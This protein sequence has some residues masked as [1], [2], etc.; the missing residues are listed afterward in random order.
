MKAENIALPI[1]FSDEHI[2]VVNKPAGLITHPGAGVHN[3][4]LCNA[5]LYHFPGMVVGNAERPGIVHRLDKDTSGVMVVA[6]TEE[7]HRHLSEQFK[8]RR[9]EKIY[10]ALC[11]GEFVETAFELKTGHARHQHN[12][13]RFSTKISLEKCHGSHV[14]IAHTSFFVEK[15]QFGLSMLTAILHTGRTHQI[16]AHLADIDHP[17]LGDEIYGGKRV[18]SGRVPEDLRAAIG[19][20]KGQALHAEVLRFFHPKYGEKL[21][22]TV[23]P[24]EPFLRVARMIP[25]RNFLT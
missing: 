4:T 6:K 13:L 18:I 16:R 17:L 5:L 7:A 21:S 14:R 24:P 20:L 25:S 8:D 3:G 19:E 1:I 11:Y 15:S 12:R 22:F 2:A 9:V 10:R 23:E